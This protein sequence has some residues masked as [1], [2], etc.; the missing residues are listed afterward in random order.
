LRSR[1]AQR[2]SWKK[3]FGGMITRTNLSELQLKLRSSLEAYR[4]LVREGIKVPSPF[5]Y[6]GPADFALGEGQFFSPL[7]LTRGMGYQ[8]TSQCYL[9]SIITAMEES[10][11]YVEG[12]ALSVSQNLP[13]LHAWNLDADGFALDRTWNPPGCLYIGVVFP[14]AL[15]WRGRRGKVY[16]I[17]D[18]WEHGFPILRKPLNSD[19]ASSIHVHPSI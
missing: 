2:G 12:Y 16:A 5:H 3:V 4:A 7:H 19:S 11:R 17:I 15:I 6:F 13:M 10:L 9:N 18:V 1:F 8:S 14:I